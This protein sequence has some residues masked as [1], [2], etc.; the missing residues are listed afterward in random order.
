M[1][2]KICAI[3]TWMMNPENGD[4]AVGITMLAVTAFML[5]LSVAQ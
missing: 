1:L 2:N 5:G 3:Y 4:I